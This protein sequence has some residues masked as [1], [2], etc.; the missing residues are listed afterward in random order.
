MRSVTTIATGPNETK[1]TTIERVKQDLSILD[2]ANDALLAAKIDEASSDIEAH[3]ARTL[4]RAT[5]TQTFWGGQGYAEYLVLDRA[6]VASITSVTVDDVAVDSDEYRLDGDAGILFRLDSS[7]Y[8][9]VWEWS[10]SIIVVFAAGF[11]LPGE[12]NRNLPFA[13]ESA[14]IELVQSFWLSRGRDPMVKAFSAPDL[15][16]YEY[17]VG[18]VGE[19]GQLPPNVWAKIAAFR[20]PQL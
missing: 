18:A 15:G 1:L 19:A 6:P 7:G 13:I 17:W 16:A 8:P 9:S 20:R 14:A 4:S 3:L 2:T 12:Q 10:K 11:L 5:L